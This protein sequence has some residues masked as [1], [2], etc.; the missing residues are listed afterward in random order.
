MWH[1]KQKEWD[2]YIQGPPATIRSR[3]I[4]SSCFFSRNMKIKIRR[5]IIEPVDLYGCET[6][7]HMIRKERRLRVFEN[8]ALTERE[9]ERERERDLVLRGIK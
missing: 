5:I 8:R 2:Y 7:S 4:F 6:W 9:R 1:A 3:I